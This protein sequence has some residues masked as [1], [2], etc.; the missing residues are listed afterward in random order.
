[1]NVNIGGGSAAHEGWLNF[2]ALTGFDLTPHSAFPVHDSTAAIVY[3]SHC[4]EHLDDK[5][6]DRMLVEARRML[7]PDG[8][9]VLKLPDYERVLDRYRAGD[10]AFFNQWGIQKLVHMWPSQ[11]VKDT[12]AARACMIFCGMWNPSYGDKNAEFTKQIGTGADAYHGPAPMDDDSYRTVLGWNSLRQIAQMM[13][14]CKKPDWHFNHQSAWSHVELTYL[15][16]I[17]GFKVVSQDA[18]DA[19]QM[20]IPDIGAQEAI[21]MY[22]VARK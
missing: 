20:P 2:D 11:E 22:V 18:E 16:E 21:S 12:I 9:L 17:H 5:T 6:I 4:F 3:S 13:A 1:M 7:A 14:A 15:L 10:E 8:H 19:E